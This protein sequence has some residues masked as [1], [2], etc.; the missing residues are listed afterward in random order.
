MQACNVSFSTI[1]ET[2]PNFPNI[3]EYADDA[4]FVTAV[5]QWQ[6]RYPAEE[7]KFWEIPAV[8]QG[9]PSPY[10]L[11]LGNGTVPRK[12]ENSIWQWVE[13]SKISEARLSAI[14]AHFPKPT[15]TGNIEADEKMYNQQLQY[16][17][18][19]YPLEY[20]R[21]F[22]AKELVA[23]NPSYEGYVKPVIM[24]RFVA[25]PIKQTLPVRSDFSEGING[26]MA[27]QLMI[28]NWYFVYE[29]QQFQQLYGKDYS[30]PE[31]FNAE[32]FR[33]QI[34]QKIYNNLHP[35]LAPKNMGK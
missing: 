26:E 24:P 20:E 1:Y 17:I 31:W 10:Y 33:N 9:N 29:P 35:E 25:F 23:L 32:Q 3:D 11:G 27:Y 16:W 6:V 34:K 5:Q 30:F 28:R 4:T 8:K 7:K 21:L 12:F 14:A 19:L 15:L 18:A 2:C 22:N 13:A